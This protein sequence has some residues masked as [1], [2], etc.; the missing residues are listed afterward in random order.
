MLK[1]RNSLPS[2]LSKKEAKLFG[3]GNRAKPNLGIGRFRVIATT[4]PI[5]R[6]AVGTEHATKTERMLRLF[7]NLLINLRERLMNSMETSRSRGLLCTNLKRAR[8][9]APP[10]R[11]SANVPVSPAVLSRY[12]KH[13]LSFA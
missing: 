8:E 11:L 10:M 12:D 7:A 4:A 2:H 5:D 6:A 1:I 13:L 9:P 3:Q